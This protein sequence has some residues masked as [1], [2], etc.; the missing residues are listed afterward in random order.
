[1]AYPFQAVVK[2]RPDGTAVLDSAH[3]NLRRIKD[4]YQII[5][6]AQLSIIALREPNKDHNRE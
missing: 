3:F 5:G 4:E 2:G 1:M 6:V